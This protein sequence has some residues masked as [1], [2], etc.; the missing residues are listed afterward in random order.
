M[1]RPAVLKT[2]DLKED[3]DEISSASWIHILRWR[4]YTHGVGDSLRNEEMD[5]I[6]FYRQIQILTTEAHSYVGD[7]NDGAVDL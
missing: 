2:W 6:Q 1:L 4:S 3:A 7:S 5:E